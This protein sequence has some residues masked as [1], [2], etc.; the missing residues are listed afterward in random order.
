[1]IPDIFLYGAIEEG[2][3]ICHVRIHLCA[4]V[5]AH[6]GAMVLPALG[7]HD[8]EL[9]EGH[10]GDIVDYR[11]F[12]RV[13]I[14]EPEFGGR[15]EDIDLDAA[16]VGMKTREAAVEFL[17]LRPA[18]FGGLQEVAVVRVDYGPF[19]PFRVVAIG[20]NDIDILGGE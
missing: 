12:K 7:L 2:V 18:L 9:E 19:D 13:N 11:R 4:E 17:V 1:M 20:N 10:D 5:L 8:K 14:G 16:I 15:H 6:V 3:Y